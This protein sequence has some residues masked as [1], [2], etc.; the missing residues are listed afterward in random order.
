[1]VLLDHMMSVFALAQSTAAP[2]CA[3]HLEFLHG[4]RIRS[5]LVHLDDPRLRMG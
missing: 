3:L 1:M 4:R 2:E 5:V